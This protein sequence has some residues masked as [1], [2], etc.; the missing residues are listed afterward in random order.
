MIRDNLIVHNRT[1]Q[2]QG[3]FD[4]AGQRHWPKALQTSQAAG[5]TAKEDWA[6]GYQARKDGVPAGLTLE[7]LKITFQD[8]VYALDPK[9]PF[10][11]WGANWK[12]K[13]EFKD[14]PSLTQALGFE[15]ENSRMLAEFPVNVAQRDFRLPRTLLTLVQHAYPQG[16]V[17]D[18]VLGIAK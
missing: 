7:D 12:R 11:I 9:Q 4:I 3:W 10:F 15:G 17:P 5:G 8:N 13:Q 18:C 14:I 6:A 2:V 16:Q 1:A